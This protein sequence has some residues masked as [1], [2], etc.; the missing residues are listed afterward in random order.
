MIGEWKGAWMIGGWMDGWTLG[1]RVGGCHT[2]VSPLPSCGGWSLVGSP[3]R[4][5]WPL[6]RSGE[7]NP[8]SAPWCWNVQNIWL[9]IGVPVKVAGQVWFH[10]AQRWLLVIKRWWPTWSKFSPV[11]LKTHLLQRYDS[12]L[13]EQ[14]RGENKRLFSIFSPHE[15]AGVRQDQRR[16]EVWGNTIVLPHQ[17]WSTLSTHTAW[18]LFM[19]GKCNCSASTADVVVTPR[20]LLHNKWFHWFMT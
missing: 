2:P 19:H 17:S 18:F 20:K 12:Y 1:E 16:V 3:P 5:V 15:S 13:R 11:D 14:T 7:T 4:C 10:V 9:I 6:R 8:V